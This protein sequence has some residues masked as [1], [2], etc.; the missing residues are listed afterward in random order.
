[1]K[2]YQIMCIIALMAAGLLSAEAHAESTTRLG[3]GVNYWVALDDID[4]DDVDEDGFSYLLSYQW[5]PGFLGMQADLE[6]FDSRFQNS[7]YAPA[8]Y[9]VVGKGLYAAAGI[10]WVYEKEWADDPFYAL[11]VGLDLALTKRL[12]LDLGLSYRVEGGVDLGDALD[13]V[14]T[15]TLYLGAAIRIGL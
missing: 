2:L 3:G 1:M 13:K 6:Y 11:K 14:D 4:L 12:Y 8:A 15:D 5:R 10:G 9:V 7:A